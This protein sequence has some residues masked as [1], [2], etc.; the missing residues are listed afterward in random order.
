[1]TFIWPVMLA[2]LI[3]V[4]L[5]ILLY[6]WLSQRRRSLAANLGSMGLADGVTESKLGKRRHIPP[7]IFLVGLTLL[8]FAMARPAAEVSLPRQEGTVILAFDVSGSMAADDLKPTRMEAAKAAAREFIQVQPASLQVGVVAFSESGFAV[9]P[10]TNDHEAIISSIERLSPQRST[11]LSAGIIAS[12]NA[13][14]VGF[15]QPPL[16]DTDLSE[17]PVPTATPLPDGILTPAVILLLTDGENTAPPDPF[18]AA[19]IAADRGIRIYTIGIGSAA[20]T[21]LEI[22]GFSVHTQLDEAV[23]KEISQLTGGEYFYPENEADLVEIYKGITPQLV[24]K[25]EQM[26]VT[27]VLAGASIFIL[28]VGGLFSLM[29]FNRLP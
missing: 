9:Q 6:L 13:I 17:S 12:L 7:L 2:A 14:A 1:M 24:V 28:L 21:T 3:L 22:N 23:L 8:L 16:V 29:W 11:S 10:P 27:P 5:A 18:P 26:E 19:Q 15:G 25:S 4:P 20:G